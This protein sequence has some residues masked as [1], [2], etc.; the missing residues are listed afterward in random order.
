MNGVQLNGRAYCYENTVPGCLGS[1]AS[2]F[3]LT[4][5]VAR[6]R[7]LTEKPHRDGN[8]LSL[9][10]CSFLDYL[11]LLA[12][13]FRNSYMWSSSTYINLL[14]FRFTYLKKSI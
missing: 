14:I 8:F 6:N 11:L 5:A 2:L 13:W 1:V 9:H 4:S 10:S 3:D 7:L 12:N